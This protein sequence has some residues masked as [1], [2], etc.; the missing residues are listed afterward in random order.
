MSVGQAS[1][2]KP[3]AWCGAGCRW[4]GW[5]IPCHLSHICVLSPRGC[6]AGSCLTLGLV[7][8]TLWGAWSKLLFDNSGD[9]VTNHRDTELPTPGTRSLQEE[10][11]FRQ[12]DT[13]VAEPAQAR[14]EQPFSAPTTLQ[15]PLL[16]RSRG[17]EGVCGRAWHQ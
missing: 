7:D 12:A 14:G 16:H 3:C 2:L 1:G 11:L 8:P 10:V 6:F 15:H 9:T 4:P 13:G 5:T 17:H